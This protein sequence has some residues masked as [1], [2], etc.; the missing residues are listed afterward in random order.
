MLHPALDPALLF[1]RFEDWLSRQ[2]HCRARFDALVLHK[3]TCSEYRLEFAMSDSLRSL[4]FQHF[5]YEVEKRP[6][7]EARDLRVVITRILE[8]ASTVAPQQMWQVTLKPKG[9]TGQHIWLEEVKAAWTQLLGW[10]CAHRMTDGSSSLIATWDNEELHKHGPQ[11][12]LEIIKDRDQGKTEHFELP[13]IWD[14]D[15]WF[16]KLAT[17]DLWDIGNLHR[18]VEVHFKA[19]PSYRQLSGVREKPM[20]FELSK[21]FKRELAEYCATDVDLQRAFIDALT[22]LAY[23][24]PDPSL[25]DEVIQSRRRR[26]ERRFRISCPKHPPF[27]AHYRIVDK[28]IVLESF[29][30]HRLDGID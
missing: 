7:P 13:L 17:L 5:P 29:G 21:T 19:C 10:L 4:V 28:V 22:K 3:R 27:R 20:P 25:G 6:V 24:L 8:M 11:M 26:G 14:E 23:R 12:L 2:E 9:V 1:Y 16:A 30:P 18:S 15:S